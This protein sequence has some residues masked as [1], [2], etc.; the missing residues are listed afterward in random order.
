MFDLFAVDHQIISSTIKFSRQKSFEGYFPFV[1][2]AP[3]GGNTRQSRQATA[4]H[5]DVVYGLVYITFVG[6]FRALT[7]TFWK[8]HTASDFHARYPAM[9]TTPESAW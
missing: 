9:G 7:L 1:M 6:I 8:Q 5:N 2:V 3:Y 4:V